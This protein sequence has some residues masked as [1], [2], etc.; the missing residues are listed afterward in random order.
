MADHTATLFL[1]LE[2]GKKTAL[3]ALVPLDPDPDVATRAWRL[4]TQDR[5][6]FYDVAVCPKGYLS[7]SCAD[8]VYRARECK[9]LQALRTL[10]LI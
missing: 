1:R 7:C 2:T 6:S 5:K 4:W 10:E 8:H 3:Y 9:H